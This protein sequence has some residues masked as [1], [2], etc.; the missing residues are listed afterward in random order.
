[1][2][3]PEGNNPGVKKSP[4]FKVNPI[5]DEL[6]YGHYITVFTGRDIIGTVIICYNHTYNHDSHDNFGLFI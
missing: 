5:N 2:F 1:M 6:T 4:G 3:W